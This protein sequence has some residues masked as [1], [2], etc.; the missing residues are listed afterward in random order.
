MK[1]LEQAKALAT[2]P[3]V[4]EGTKNFLADSVSALLGDPVAAGKIMVSLIESPFFFREKLFWIKF[5]CFLS[6][7]DMDNDERA[8]FCARLTE[9]GKKGDNP[10]RLLQAIDHAETRQKVDYL[11]NASRSLAAGFIDLPVYFRICNAITNTIEEDLE[12]LAEHIQDNEDFPYSDTIQGLMNV[13]LV[14]QSVID[15]N[16]DNRYSFTPFSDIIDQFAVSFNNVERYPMIGGVELIRERP[17]EQSITQLQW[18][19]FD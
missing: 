10:Y 7:I 15:G 16:G 1:I 18:G 9:D 6:G 4:K 5:E 11:I 19:T 17:M 3:E 2:D 14:Y 8:K 13:G 12:F